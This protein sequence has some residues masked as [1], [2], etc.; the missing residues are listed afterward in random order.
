LTRLE[1]VDQ[2]ALRELLEASLAATL[3]DPFAVN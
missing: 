2:A 3:A 1:G